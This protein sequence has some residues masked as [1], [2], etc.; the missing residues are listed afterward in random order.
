MINHQHLLV[1]DESYNIE[2]YSSLT[3]HQIK[4]FLPVKRKWLLAGLIYEKSSKW[5]K[6]K[7]VSLNKNAKQSKTKTVEKEDNTKWFV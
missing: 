5:N 2:F 7:D 4:A 6:P 3:A 1:P